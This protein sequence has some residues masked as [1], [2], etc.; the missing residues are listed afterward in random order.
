MVL[1]NK[2]KIFDEGTI[3]F[4]LIEKLVRFEGVKEKGWFNFENCQLLVDYQECSTL[5]HPVS[6]QL[7]DK[8][9]LVETL[10][11]VS[12]FKIYIFF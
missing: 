10:V 7:T 2:T 5:V 3:P 9:F 6:P 4:M 1:K 8:A 12:S 11:K